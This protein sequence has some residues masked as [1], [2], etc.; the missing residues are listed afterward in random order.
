MVQA[1]ESF[2]IYP[3]MMII[4]DQKILLL[5]RADWAPLWPSHWHCPIGK[6]EENESPRQTAIRETYEEVGLKV[7][8]SLATVV[9]VQ[10]PHFKNPDLTWKDI[11]LFFI[12]NDFEGEPINK[13]PRLHDAMDWFDINHLPEPII[14][15]VKFGIEQYTKG[16]TYGEFEY[17]D[18]T[19]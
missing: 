6:M 16:E 10:A 14:P 19:C 3:N 11:G 1:L 18:V 7:N 9:A 8:P 5:R 4:R 15:V 2:I 12:A 13:E 17:G